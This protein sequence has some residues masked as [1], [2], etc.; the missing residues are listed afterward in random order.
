M[1]LLIIPGSLR[2]ESYNKKLAK[3]A[4]YYAKEAG[5]TVTYLD[6]KDL[7][8]PLLDQDDADTKPFPENVLKAQKLLVESNAFLFVTPEY[9][10]SVP[11][12]LKN[13]IDW[14]SRSSS[15]K[16]P[17]GYCFSKKVAA[18]MSA[19]LSPYG[20]IRAVLHLREIL[21]ILGTLVLP[22]EKTI[23][24]AHE[25]FKDDESISKHHA[26]IKKICDSLYELTKKQN[27]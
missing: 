26:G 25:A 6:L 10:A 3:I 17:R 22:H 12:V 23:A 11:G 19:S 7:P 9:N 20:G 1:K 5:F 13:F 2:K 14:V 27:N 21:S 15:E 16:E 4:E 8:L 18:I 24:S